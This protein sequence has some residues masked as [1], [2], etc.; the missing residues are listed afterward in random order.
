MKCIHFQML[1]FRVNCAEIVNWVELLTLIITL[2]TLSDLPVI[3]NSSSDFCS[4]E[5]AL[6]PPQP[7]GQG[8]PY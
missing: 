5:P 3:Y 7:F 4:S 8:H 2:V 6:N 1:Y